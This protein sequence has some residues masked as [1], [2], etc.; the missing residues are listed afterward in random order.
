MSLMDL[1]TVVRVQV[2]RDELAQPNWYWLVSNFMHF[3]ENIIR[4]Q[5]LSALLFFSS[6]SWC[7]TLE[8][9]FLIDCLVS[10][11][12]Y[13]QNNIQKNFFHCFLKFLNHMACVL[14]IPH[15]L[16]IGS[17]NSLQMGPNLTLQAS[18]VRFS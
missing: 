4:F 8:S 3:I 15:Q 7:W 2:T 16:E 14:E 11:I 6:F 9:S 5:N 18:F 12:S 13:M 10:K 1:A 17:F